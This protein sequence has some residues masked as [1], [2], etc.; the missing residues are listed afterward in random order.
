MQYIISHILFVP[1][2]L[3]KAFFFPLYDMACD[4]KARIICHSH[5]HV[6]LL[7]S[8]AF[9]KKKKTK[10]YQANVGA[11]VNPHARYVH[12]KRLSNTNERLPFFI[13]FFIYV[14]IYY[15]R[16]FIPTY[17]PTYIH[18]YTYERLFAFSFFTIVVFMLFHTSVV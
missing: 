8:L 10:L 6:T 7:G 4:L 9:R 12:L 17:I 18:T 1:V 13:F 15:I 3:I 11:K 2:L 14:F 5:L 16:T